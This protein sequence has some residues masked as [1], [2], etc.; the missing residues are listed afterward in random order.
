MKIDDSILIRFINN[1]LSKSERYKIQLLINNIQLLIQ[2]KIQ[3][4]RGRS[5]NKTTSSHYINIK[6]FS[7]I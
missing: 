4:I 7:E 2:F 1:D 6:L 3:R 5:H